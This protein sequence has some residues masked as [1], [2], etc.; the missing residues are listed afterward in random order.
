MLG[1]YWLNNLSSAGPVNKVHGSGAILAA[2]FPK[3]LLHKHVDLKSGPHSLV[4]LNGAVGFGFGPHWFRTIAKNPCSTH[5]P[6]RKPQDCRIVSARI[7]LDQSPR[8][9]IKVV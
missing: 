4:F 1:Q 9:R 2:C 8:A 3:V 7:F 5:V 6:A